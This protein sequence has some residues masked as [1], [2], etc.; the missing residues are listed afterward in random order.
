VSSLK[1]SLLVLALALPLMAVGLHADDVARVGSESISREEF[2]AKAQIEEARLQ[3]KLTKDERLSLLRAVVNQRLLVAEA[4]REK[5]DRSAQHKA[6]M[7]EFERKALADRVY[8]DQVA[9][10]S[11]VSL[12]E[13]HKIYDQHPEAFD[14]IELSQVLVAAP[15]GKE[16]EAEKRA[17][18]LKLSL[19]KA[20]KTFAAVARAQSDD[21]LSKPRGGDLGALHRGQLEADL[22]KAAFS[23]K[24]PGII[25]PV[26]TQFGY[27]ILYVRSIKHL[28][29][30]EAGPSL[31]QELQNDR[32]SRTQAALLDKLAQKDK[33]TLFEDK[34]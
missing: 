5:L 11:Q 3:R 4:R 31:Q 13:A 2:E 29:W 8:N 32:S 9:G 20:P 22:E 15:A 25:G 1:K 17:I 34:L 6:A 24:Q 33:V 18:A 12:D 30:D 10:P 21:T 28:S 19:S 23:A 27:H 14:Q 7:A 16:A 26:K